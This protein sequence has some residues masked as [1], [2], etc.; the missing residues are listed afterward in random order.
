[1]GERR[2]LRDL[3]RDTDFEQRRIIDDLSSY[4]DD[5]DEKDLSKEIKRGG[6]S[7]FFKNLFVGLF[8]VAIVI[9]SF[10][11]SFLVGKR[12]L[13]PPIKNIPTVEFPKP[14]AVTP[15]QVKTAEKVAP[16]Q[17]APA[18][19]NEPDK[20]VATAPKVTTTTQSDPAIYAAKKYYKVIAGTFASSGDAQ[21]MARRLAKTGFPYYIKKM[22]GM[23]RV[24]VGALEARNQAQTLVAR[25]KAKGFSSEIVYE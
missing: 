21:V 6:A 13:V 9:G 5:Q 4:R 10:W 22:S 19:V 24:Q 18:V 1:M 2:D 20:T 23:W 11:I 25:L 12:V 7:D 8:L 14:K 15:L 3:L 17:A 16:V